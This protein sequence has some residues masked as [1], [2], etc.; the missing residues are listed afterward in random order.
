MKNQAM[1]NPLR[2]SLRKPK[3]KTKNVY[4]V[5]RNGKAILQEIEWNTLEL[6][7]YEIDHPNDVIKCVS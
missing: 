4:N 7:S 6:N 5:F 3:D 2:A 1:G